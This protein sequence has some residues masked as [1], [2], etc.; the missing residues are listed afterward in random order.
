MRN[1]IRHTPE[2]KQLARALRRSGLS[3]KDIAKQLAISS[4]SVLLWTKDI[5]L[6]PEQKKILRNRWT[7]S[8][9]K[10]KPEQ[11]KKS[12]I[13][14]LSAY[15]KPTPS[16]E[17]LLKRLQKFY[18]THGRIPLKREFNSTYIQYL[19]RFGGWNN[20]IKLAGFEPHNVI[21]SKKHIA[22]DGHV[23]DSV[24][25]KI[26]D[27]W[28][29]KNNI[30]HERNVRYTNTKMTADFAVDKAFIEY[31]GLAGESKS[32]DAVIERKRDFCSEHGLR[33]IEIYPKDLFPNK[34]SEIINLP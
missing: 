23:C 18:S 26:V 12:A 3:H 19:K 33:L 32:Y 21:F 17:E 4:S 22:K 1:G 30:P 31:F 16:N 13:K 5:E 14:N 10:I 2:T 9:Q 34:L 11:L 15:W 7:I 29:F 24:A 6:S 27:D 25:E 28:L 20:A 8:L